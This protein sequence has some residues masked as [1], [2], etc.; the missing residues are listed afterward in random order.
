MSRAISLQTTAAAL[1]LT[2]FAALPAH[3][4]E[5][6]LSMSVAA[7]DK[8]TMASHKNLAPANTTTAYTHHGGGLGGGHPGV[9]P[10]RNIAVVS[11]NHLS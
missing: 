9:D 1:A 2:L 8:L 6:P 5:N 11:Y 3:A 10:S 7:T 4:G